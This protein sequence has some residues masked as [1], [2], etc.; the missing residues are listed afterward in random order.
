MPCGGI[1]VSRLQ[2]M[3]TVR[4][5]RKNMR[6]RITKFL[7]SCLV[8]VALSLVLPAI[9]L[10]SEEGASR[11]STLLLVGRIFNVGLVVFILVWV[12]RKPLSE[13]FANRTQSIREQL[14]EAQR[15]RKEAETRLAEIRERMRNVDQE[16]IHIREAAERDAKAEYERL[17]AAAQSDAEKILARTR[18]EIDGM[19]RAA[20]LELKAYAAQLSVQLA[21]DKIREEITDEDR[22]RLFGRFVNQVGGKG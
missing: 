14:E 15:A 13:F 8:L 18:Q 2:Q 3:F 19:T 12:G 10:A 22:A 11:G 20:H 16:L 4:R 17:I 9:V 21:E 1:P 6:T 5:V 7:I